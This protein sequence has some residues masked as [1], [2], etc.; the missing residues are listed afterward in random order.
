[1]AGKGDGVSRLSDV[2]A[3][4]GGFDSLKGVIIG[5]LLLAVIETLAAAYIS[6]AAKSAA[7]FVLVFLF[8]LIRPEGLFTTGT[9]RHA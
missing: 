9:R 7:S 5:G 8:L 3:V 6:S 4:I 1:M 2:A